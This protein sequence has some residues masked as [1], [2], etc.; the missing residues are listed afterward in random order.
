MSHAD[1]REIFS[2][3]R[4]NQAAAVVAVGHDRRRRNLSSDAR[5]GRS[6]NPS[7][8]RRAQ[9]YQPSPSFAMVKPTANGPDA[10]R[11]DH[12]LRRR[13]RQHFRRSSRERLLNLDRKLREIRWR[14]PEARGRLFRDR[15]ATA[16]SSPGRL[17]R[18][19][20]RPAI[21]A[22]GRQRLLV[23]A[24]RHA[25]RTEHR[26]AHDAAG[27][28]CRS[29]R[30]ARAA[31]SSPRRLNTC[32]RSSADGRRAPGRDST[33]AGRRGS[34]RPMGAA[35]PDGIQETQTHRPVPDVWLISIRG[36]TISPLDAGRAGSFHD[37][38]MVLMS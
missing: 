9:K 25:D 12:L 5:S 33:A 34:A 13:A 35:R 11:R 20:A 8:C 14:R 7:C 31:G 2:L 27:T 28:A 15:R 36:V 4:R 30:S 6:G 26:V 18:A 19:R 17:H 3:Q 37:F 21:C 29:R 10:N 32:S 23:G 1:A 22:I 38:R 24:V 16:H